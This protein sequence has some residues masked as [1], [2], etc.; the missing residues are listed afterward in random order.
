M[1]RHVVSSSVVGVRVVNFSLVPLT[2]SG[3]SSKS[4]GVMRKP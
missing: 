3:I 4:V 1:C 2:T